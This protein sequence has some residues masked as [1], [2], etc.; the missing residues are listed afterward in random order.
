MNRIPSY[1]LLL[2]ALLLSFSAQAQLTVD[3]GYT[4]Q[5]LIED[6]LVGGGVEVSNFQFTG[7]ENARGFFDGSNSNIGLG[8]GIVISTGRAG[9]ASGPN[10]SPLSDVGT[11]FSGGGDAALT[12]IT[13]IATYDA[14]VL[15]FDFVPSSDTVQFNY[16]FA[17]NEYMLYVGT[18]VNDVF[19]FLISG[20][21]IVGEQNVALIPGTTTP[22]AI[23]NVNANAGSNPQYY[24]DNENPP[25]STVEY[26]G[27]TQ[28][29]TATAVLQPCQT[30]RIR[31]AIA[32]AG[33]GTFDS[34]VFLEAGSFASSVVSIDAESSFSASASNQELVEGCSSMN[35]NFYRTPP[36]DDELSVG[37]TL[38]GSATNGVDI[39]NI[40]TMITFPAGSS[41][42]S[43]SFNVLEDSDAEGVENMTITLDQLNLC[44][45]D[46]PNSITFSIQDMEPMTVSITPAVTFVCPEE[47]EITVVPSGGYPT[48]EY[49]WTS[50]VE[51]EASISVFPIST[52]T[53]FVT[54]T[55]ACG[56]SEVASTTVSIPNYMPL[57]VS[58]AD[59][60]VCNGDDALLESV[61]SGGL[62]TISYSWQGGGSDPNYNFTPTSSTTVTLT[63]TDD[64]NLSE[65]A[66]ANVEVDEVEASFTHRLSGHATVQFTT[67][68]YNIYEFD[69]DFGDGLSST[70]ES[71]SHTYD[72]EGTYPVTLT[73]VNGNGC[74]AILR[75]T[76]TVYPPLH[77]YIPNAFTPNGDGVNDVFGM[78]GEGYLYYDL[79]IYDRW[80]NRLRFGRFKDATAWDGTYK[81]NTVPADAYVYK[82]FVQPPIGIEFRETGLIHVLFKE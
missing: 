36:L 71:P 52:A 43:I 73:V 61:V 46:P 30:Y 37:L 58:V 18:G 34:A 10:G 62:G 14:A 42:A 65:L 78:V 29:F 19:A 41:T 74:V 49:S 72:M 68:S 56:Q 33:D 67:N 4:P 7:N 31:L 64:C 35:L 79:E 53:Y 28:V 1:G 22:V 16:V 9:D 39:S 40:P 13:G 24:I 54:V 48:Y 45:T 3:V 8:S 50:L 63:V 75:D 15:S 6:V 47:Y 2:V 59:I 66:T 51:T 5:Q 55:D 44:A 80:G 25:G 82:I 32:D 11:D 27:F 21:G 38:T 12:A 23:D 57:Q 70:G 17:S 76:V 60:T 69:W 81:G 20:P 26:N 77:V